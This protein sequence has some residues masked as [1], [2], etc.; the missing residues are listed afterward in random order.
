MNVLDRILPVFHRNYPGEHRDD[1]WNFCMSKASAVQLSEANL[2][3]MCGTD[4][5]SGFGGGGGKEEIV[6]LAEALGVCGITNPETNAYYGRYTAPRCNVD[7]L[8]P[9]AVMDKIQTAFP[10]PIQFPPF[11]GNCLQGT[12]TKYGVTSNRHIFYLWV[13]KR[14]LELCPNRAS[15]IVEVGAGFGVLGYYLDRLGYRDYTTIDL[16]LINACQT[17]FLYKNLPGR[18]FILSGDVPNP[19]DLQHRDSIKLLHS[20]DFQNVPKNRFS[21][22]VNM[23][24]LTEYGIADAE[25]YVQSDCAPMLL[26]INHEVNPFRV[27]ELPQDRR[28]RKYRN[29]FWLRPGYVEELYVSKGNHV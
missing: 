9:D 3:N 2:E 5:V 15:G 26:S 16:A 13:A 21:I 25:K 12:Q 23:D 1:V 4:L 19:F 6:R 28:I 11:S 10:F 27:C 17:Y 7:G 22:M 18:N 14:I 20:G 24:G 29:L 8:S